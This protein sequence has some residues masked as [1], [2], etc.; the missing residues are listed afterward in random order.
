MWRYSKVIHGVAQAQKTKSLN[1]VKW[2]DREQDRDYH[3]Q[4]PSKQKD[5]IDVLSPRMSLKTNLK[6]HLFNSIS[7]RLFLESISIFVKCSP[8]NKGYGSKYYN[9]KVDSNTSCCFSFVF[10]VFVENLHSN[11]KR[12]G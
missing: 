2:M 5:G 6:I 12:Q 1:L 8:T 10:I 3:E 9:R 4:K 11:H 7:D